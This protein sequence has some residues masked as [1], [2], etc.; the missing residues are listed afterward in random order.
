MAD[1]DDPDDYMINED[2]E[3]E[4]DSDQDSRS[5]DEPNDEDLYFTAKDKS[6]FSEA[7]PALERVLHAEKQKGEWGFKALKRMVKLYFENNQPEKMIEKYRLLLPYI[8]TAVTRNV[9]EKAIHKILG[10][11]E[12]TPFLLDF[13]QTTLVAL[14]EAKNEKFWFKINVKLANFYFVNQDFP[15]MMQLCEELMANCTRPDGTIDSNRSGEFLELVALQI[16]YFS[17]QKNNKKLKQLYERAKPHIGS[18]LV[19]GRILGTILE[20]GGKMYMYERD[21]DR[22]YS[23]F[24]EAFVRY[25]SGGSPRR[26]QCLKYLVLAAMLKPV[27]IDPFHSQETRDFQTDAEVSA[28]HQLIQ[29]SQS[30]NI[31]Q[32][33]RILAENERT[34]M[35]DPFIR[36]YIEDL[37]KNIR[38]GKLLKLISPYSTLRLPFLARTL[39]S[40]VEEV[41]SMLVSLILD[42]QILGRVDQINQI[43]ILESKTQAGR[44]YQHLSSW[45]SEISG[46]HQTAMGKL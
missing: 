30:N 8:K 39:N 23:D 32:F 5:N 17:L 35:G 18:S 33:E 38:V 36:M 46:L 13:Y 9:S 22:A 1:F 3:P 34:I 19:H 2:S 26:I 21:F 16:Q 14:K 31:P 4:D 24:F 42:G 12:T 43:L 37:M 27:P 29:A 28:F 44:K 45:A 25:D 40:P 6:K 11:A 7:I 10:R 20:C 15:S 41:E